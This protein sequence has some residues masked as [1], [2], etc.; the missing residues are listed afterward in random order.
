MR[1]ALTHQFCWPEVRRGA[2][3]YTHELAAGLR[4][5]GHDAVIVSSA[6]APGSE[7]VLDVPVRR[8]RQRNLMRRRFGR[9][10]GG[11][12]FGAQTLWAVGRHRYDVWH[13]M[14]VG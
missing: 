1:I 14:S 6:A 10:S 11:V 8:L 4:R 12:A 9:A 3:R 2:E 5:A 13:A 7:L